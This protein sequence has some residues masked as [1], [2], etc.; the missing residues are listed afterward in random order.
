MRL[1]SAFEELA[2]AEAQRVAHLPLRQAMRALSAAEPE[3][4]QKWHAPAEQHDVLYS[5]SE[6]LYTI[7]AGLQ[8]GARRLSALYAPGKQGVKRLREDLTNMLRLLDE[9]EK[10]F[11]SEAS[12]K[13]LRCIS[14]EFP[15][16]GDE[17][18]MRTGNTVFLVERHHQIGRFMVSRFVASPG[19]AAVIDTTETARTRDLAEQSLASLGAPERARWFRKPATDELL[20]FMTPL[21]RQRRFESLSAWL[22]LESS[23]YPE[24][25]VDRGTGARPPRA[26][27]VL[28][29]G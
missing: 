17:T 29:D 23:D 24:E 25:N 12:R 16:E 1:A 7:T 26:R 13:S 19:F 2:P 22:D 3:K 4:P 8:S 15:V 10:G 28:L 5:I 6:G 20:L 11:A 27:R 21:A 14:Y 9:Y 18:V